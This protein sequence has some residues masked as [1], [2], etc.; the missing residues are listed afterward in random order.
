MWKV[1]LVSEEGVK[2]SQTLA[3]APKRPVAA[4]NTEIQQMV[5]QAFPDAPIMEKVALN[6]SNFNPTAKNPNSS[7]KG[8]FQILNRTWS[9]YGC[10]GNVYDAADN[11]R[12][13]RVIY[14]ESGLRPWEASRYEGFAGGWGR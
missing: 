4:S 5:R 1:A 9:G 8:V 12:C 3:L 6:E 11:I 14:D 13:A 7:A 2:G 10:T